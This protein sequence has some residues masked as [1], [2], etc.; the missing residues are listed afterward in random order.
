MCY[1]GVEDMNLDMFL[2]GVA[3][4]FSAFFS[5]WVATKAALFFKHLLQ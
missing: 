2:L 1:P 4:G 3:V 5:T